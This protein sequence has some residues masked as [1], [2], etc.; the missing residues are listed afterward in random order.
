MSTA[1]LQEPDLLTEPGL[2][3][4]SD[5]LFEVIDGKVVE[6]PPMSILA[7]VVAN[8]LTRH[9]APHA[10][11]QNV[12]QVGVE[13]LFDLG[14]L[15]NRRRRPDF[16]VVSFARWAEDRPLPEQGN[17]W[18]VVPDLAVEVISPTDLAEELQ[19]KLA[20]YFQ[21]GVRLVWVIYPRLRIVHVYESLTRID[22]LLHEHELNGGEVLPGFRL[23]LS[24]LFHGITAPRSGVR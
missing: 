18:P 6:L 3:G 9:I 24:K 4:E 20:D 1:T 13:L 22:C 14:P 8:R 5:T 15:V 16:A 21:A 19:D 23:P 2:N 12:G 17:A 10:D 7:T 11:S